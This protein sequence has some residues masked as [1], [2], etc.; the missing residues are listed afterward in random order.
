VVLGL[1]LTKSTVTDGKLFRR[2]IFQDASKTAPGVDCANIVGS[3][4]AV[5][6]AAAVNSAAT[7]S[8]SKTTNGAKNTAGMMK[9]N[10]IQQGGV[11]TATGIAST[12]T[13]CASIMKRDTYSQL[14]LDKQCKLVSSLLFIRYLYHW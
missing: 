1:D 2:N 4:K 9:P 12:A 7:N 11:S 10:E 8:A 6:S 13:G 3:N 5:D 14:S